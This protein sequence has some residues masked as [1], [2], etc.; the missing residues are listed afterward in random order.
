MPPRRAWGPSTGIDLL[1]WVSTA[2]SEGAARINEILQ[3]MVELRDVNLMNGDKEEHTFGWQGRVFRARVSVGKGSYPKKS[4]LEVELT[5]ELNLRLL[6]YQ[7]SPWYWMTLGDYPVLGWRSGNNRPKDE[8]DPTED[9]WFTEED[10]II[11]M[12]DLAREGLLCK[13]R[14]CHCGDWFFAKIANQKFCCVRCQQAYFRSNEDYRAYRRTYMKNLR[15]QHKETYHP[16]P[17]DRAKKAKRIV[18][19]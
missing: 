6:R 3:L 13:V 17:K 11:A 19:P 10:A 4:D 15:A 7:L 8:E 2:K 16:S 1:A 5:S 18:R 12:I 14:R 9:V